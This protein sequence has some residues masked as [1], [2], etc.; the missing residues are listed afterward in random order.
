M[1]RPINAHS[2]LVD[3]LRRVIILGSTGSIGTQTL[4]VLEHLNALHAQGKYP[5]RYQVVGLAARKNAGM[6]MQQAERWQVKDLALA[7]SGTDASSPPGT[8]IGLS[9]VSL[10]TG[11]SAAETLVR[12]VHSDIVVSSMVGASGLPATLAA[13]QLGRDIALAN[14]ESLVAAGALVIPAARAS[15]SRLLPVD[16]EHAAIWQCLQG[17]T[18][19]ASAAN[20]L[21][22]PCRVDSQVRRVI[23]TASGGPFRTWNLQQAYDATPE[24]ALK[25][26][27]WSMGAK[28]TIDS[29]NLTNKAFEVLE[30]HWLFGLEPDRIGVLIHP[31]SIVHSLV[32]YADGSL[33]AQLGPPDMRSPIQYA[34]TFP[35]RPEG[36]SRRLDLMS[37]S[38]LEFETPSHERFPAL[39]H[40]QRVMTH[41]GTAGSTFNA[42]SEAA[43]EAF[44]QR[45]I[46]FGRITELAGEALDA[47]PARDVLSLDDV[48]HADAEARRF[49]RSRITRSVV[50]VAGT[51]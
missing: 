44:L 39:A 32:E 14:K 8:W 5:H 47:H 2:A 28:V 19:P 13:V 9:R 7:E 22:P 6:L 36:C 16:S 11:P 31:Q 12:E 45:Q 37:M 17:L 26:P 18:S 24:Q 48:L 33:I 35:A 42:A 30:A 43:V 1:S 49:V 25:H 51:A 23:L 15:G 3:S 4:E 10:R 21:C 46:P 38:K 40:A 41:G 50:G 27:T 20:P 29:A 34:F